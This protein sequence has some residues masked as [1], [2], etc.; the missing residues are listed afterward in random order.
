MNLT[1]NF[2]IISLV[3]ILTGLN[4]FKK[5]RLYFTIIQFYFKNPKL[6]NT[7]REIVFLSLGFFFCLPI[8]ILLHYGQTNPLLPISTQ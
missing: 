4:H 1:W 2:Y 5:T 6:R 8:S 7:I 3:G